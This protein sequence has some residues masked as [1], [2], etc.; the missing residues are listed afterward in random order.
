MKLI[1]R[2]SIILCCGVLAVMAADFWVKKPFTKWSPNEVNRMLTDS[3]WAKNVSLPIGSGGELASISGGG[4]GT[5]GLGAGSGSYNG[6][7]SL[8]EQGNVNVQ[9][10][11]QS[12]L[13]VRQALVLDKYGAEKADSAEAKE[14]LAKE[15]DSY[16][17]GIIGL[18]MDQ[19]PK[20]EARLKEIATTA[21]VLNLKGK[22]PIKAVSAEAVPLGDS[23]SLYF[24]FPRTTA[25]TLD[26]DSVE[27]SCRLDK[28]TVKRKFTLKDMQFDG[29]LDL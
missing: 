7:A 3:P 16:I 11:W 28:L 8:G 2:I 18:P 26:E 1:F 20:T 24:H 15:P 27:F 22:D 13:P 4:G 14:Y 23:V 10:Q 17:V 5:A 25:I 12:A 21:A 29:K 9:V 6:G 19:A